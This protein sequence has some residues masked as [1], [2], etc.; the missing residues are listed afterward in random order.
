M[1]KI[2]GFFMRICPFV[3]GSFP[4]F[5]KGSRFFPLYAIF[6]LVS[7]GCIDTHL[8]CLSFF[9]KNGIR[10]KMS[11]DKDGILFYNEENDWTKRRYFCDLSRDACVAALHAANPYRTDAGTCSCS[12]VHG[13]QSAE[14]VVGTLS[15]RDRNERKRFCVCFSDIG[16]AKTGILCRKIYFAVHYGIQRTY[17]D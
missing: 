9:V 11:L 3:S 1:L 5:E 4:I 7:M 10:G 15:S 13:R 2:S 8:Q 12:A 14:C 6:L 17:G 16:S